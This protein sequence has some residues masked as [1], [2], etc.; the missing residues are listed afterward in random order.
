MVYLVPK[1]SSQSSIQVLKRRNSIVAIKSYLS[2]WIVT[3]L[4][5]KR[6]QCMRY[7]IG[8][9]RKQ[10]SK[11]ARIMGSGVSKVLPS[12]FQYM[13]FSSVILGIFI[14][15]VGISSLF[16][17]FVLVSYKIW[18]LITVYCPLWNNIDLESVDI[19]PLKITWLGNQKPRFSFHP[20]H[21]SVRPVI[22][23]IMSTTY[24]LNFMKVKVK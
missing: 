21:S 15:L 5:L 16:C 22:E 4:A 19:F 6:L 10:E 2:A 24:P 17:G 8:R 23:P 1:L 3:E 12:L 13:N 18:K 11:S 20:F 9:W 7:L 14:S